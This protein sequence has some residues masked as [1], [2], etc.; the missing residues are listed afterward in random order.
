MMEGNEEAEHK[1]FCDTEMGANKMTRE[2]K[3]TDVEELTASIEESTA[4]IEKLGEEIADLS[5]QIA[6]I[7]AALA[8]ATEIRTAE[9]AKNAATV[10]EAIG[11]ST[12]VNQ[13]LT[14]LKNFY[15]SATALVQTRASSVRAAQ[16]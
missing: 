3:T 5:Q 2:Q 14:V 1:G 10:T 9:K 11:A 15:E 6:D 7:N 16:P 4:S 12:A 13:A 8:A